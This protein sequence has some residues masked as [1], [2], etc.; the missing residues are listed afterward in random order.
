[1]VDHENLVQEAARHPV[2]EGGRVGTLPTPASGAFLELED[3][4]GQEGEKG[5]HHLGA[6]FGASQRV[7]LHPGEEESSNEGQYAGEG[8]FGEGATLHPLLFGDVLPLQVVEVEL[9]G[10]FQEVPVPLL[11]E[12]RV[13]RS[14]RGAKGASGGRLEVAS[15]GFQKGAGART[16][17]HGISGERIDPDPRDPGV[18][19]PDRGS[20]EDRAVGGPGPWFAPLSPSLHPG[21]P[22]PSIAARITGTLRARGVGRGWLIP[23]LLLP[24][25]A[26]TYLRL[27]ENPFHE[28]I[29]GGLNL[30][31]HEIGHILFLPLPDFWTVAGGTLVELAIPVGAG[32]LFFLRKED[33]GVAFSLFWLGT[34]LAGVALYAGDARLQALPLVSPFSGTPQH[35]W[36]FLLREMGMLEQDRT[37]FLLFR[38]MGLVA[39]LAALALSAWLA[40]ALLTDPARKPLG[41]SSL[42]G[43]L[44]LM[45]RGG[46]G[47]GNGRG[48]ALGRVHRREDG[49]RKDPGSSASEEARLR[50]FL[51]AEGVE[52]P[53]EQGA[54][55]PGVMPVAPRPQGTPPERPPEPENTSSPGVAPMANPALTAL[56]EKAAHEGLTPEEARFLQFLEGSEDGPVT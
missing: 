30:A 19:A 17:G 10:L 44:P 47:Q 49:I 32:I 56:R 42:L 28:S 34:V 6:G 29:L 37:L 3:P 9:L 15:A 5:L 1:M 23:A 54:P 31:L 25:F 16:L 12:R 51:A 21:G 18:V 43:S 26:L 4:L 40:L 13:H 11:G 35:D 48:P 20:P 39:M 7:G 46:E 33:A 27:L 55:P 8:E 14:L 2:F 53:I 50:A 45:R 52:L 36:A 22:L 41:G 24:W 38:R